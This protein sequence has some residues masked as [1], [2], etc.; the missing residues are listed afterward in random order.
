MPGQPE[1]KIVEYERKYA[2][3]VAEM[4]NRSASE[5]GGFGS[6]LDEER[7]IAE[8]ED[9]DNLNIYLALDG[10][11]V[12]GY[13]SFAEYR[14][15]K[16]ASY[17]PLLNVRPDYHGKKVGKLLILKAVERA[18]EAGW[19]R[20]DLYTWPGNVK[21]VPLYK[22]CG[23]FWEKRDDST[24]LMNFLPYVMSTEAVADF[25][26]HADWYADSVREL[27]VKPDGRQENHF[28]YMEYNWQKDD[29]MLR[30]EF[31]RRGRGLRLIETD[32]YLIS[33]TVEDLKLVFDRSYKVV[34]RIVNKSGAPLNVE[35]AGR[36]DE[37]I[38][39]K[40]D[41]KV[42]LAEK[43]QEETVE[44]QFYVGP[45]EEEQNEGKTHPTVT[46]DLLI[47]G[48]QALFKVGTVPQF[49]AAIEAV[50]TEEEGIAGQ[51]WGV[52]LNWENNFRQ[53]ASFE[54][55][56]PESGMVELEQRKYRVE[57][58]AGQ[59]A[60]LP[61]PGR[62]KTPGWYGGK[63]QV[64][65]TLKDGEQVKYEHELN[66]V[67]PG[68]GAAFG[69][70]D[71]DYWMLCNGRFFVRLRK[72]NNSFGVGSITSK[73]ELTAFQ[74][75]QVGPPWTV[76]L[77]RV[78][79][80]VE[81]HGHGRSVTMEAWFASPSTPG[82]EVAAVFTLYADGVVEYC[83]RLENHSRNQLEVK[84]RI[85]MMQNFTRALLPHGDGVV[86]V[87][88]SYGEGM[89]SF[90]TE[91]ITENWIF[92]R[93]R[94][95]SRGICWPREWQPRLV[96]DLWQFEE[97]LGV[98][99]PDK[100]VETQSLVIAINTWSRWQDFRRYATGKKDEINPRHNLELDVNGR[101]PFVAEQF[102]VTVRD[103]KASAFDGKVEIISRSGLIPPL[104]VKHAADEKVRLAEFTA[105]TMGDACLDQLEMNV[106]FASVGFSRRRTVLRTRGTVST[107]TKTLEGK[108]VLTVDNGNVEFS[109][110]PE[111]APTVF[112]LKYNG[113]EWL[114][115]SF[116]NP[117][118]CSWWNPWLGGVGCSLDDEISALSL[119]EEKSRA[120][121]VTMKDNKGN[122]WQG[123]ENVTA[124]DCHEK[125]RGLEMSQYI[126]TLPGVPLVCSVL[127]VTNNTGQTM[128]DAPLGMDIF[129]NTQGGW[130]TEHNRQGA[131]VTY[132]LSPEAGAIAR[133]LDTMWFGNSAAQHVAQ[134]IC[135][136]HIYGYIN[137]HVLHP[138]VPLEMTIASGQSKFSR[139][140]FILFNHEPLDVGSLEDF[141][142]IRF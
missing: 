114:S 139:P 56:L 121:F 35:L 81:F 119:L 13:C 95:S 142:T 138:F 59:K 26:R 117:C 87:D 29:R 12:V 50:L 25:F 27:E 126:L 66:V 7:V 38:R 77:R 94:D 11:Q 51:P 28:E 41:E 137:P 109:A 45:I 76:E 67:I 99:D 53:A 83:M 84:C 46:A 10:Q 124:F 107:A 24:H 100:K 1:I 85:A 64:T 36:D 113:V 78:K 120:A 106:D 57:L 82:L 122:S 110:A 8:N 89:D 30:M 132:R 65:A 47:N 52:C 123:L 14:A 61:V 91:K 101:N 73:K 74:Y 58:A 69:G 93:G 111:Y 140:V 130:M 88:G 15:D 37:N 62:L 127:K 72:L 96:D 39:F 42:I 21:A 63:T 134:F 9:S 6:L 60:S 70:Q 129:L 75:P 135:D 20:L 105:K 125:C 136:G 86:E 133:S 18:I 97:D 23:F 71:K 98:L 43:G 108:E 17:I 128:V 31:E 104:E 3:A 141:K 32:D 48:K 19:P 102:P 33:A 22:K 5:W 4:W 90:S 40:L 118:A 55:E 112:S 49:P 92:I 103:H 80:R 34:Y 16:G 44:A 116:P 115:S 131:G 54:I 79:P 68:V 2:A